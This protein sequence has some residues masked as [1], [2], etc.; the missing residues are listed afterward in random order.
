MHIAYKFCFICSQRFE[1]DLFRSV[2]K[3]IIPD[4]TPT[5]Q[6]QGGVTQPLIRCFHGIALTP[7]RLP[8][9]NRFKFTLVF[10]IYFN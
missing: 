4:A 1:V 6:E 7:R 2:F 9:L 5:F 8:S 10:A 3:K